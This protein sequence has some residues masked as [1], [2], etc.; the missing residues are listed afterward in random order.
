MLRKLISVVLALVVLAVAVHYLFGFET[1]YVDSLRGLDLRTIL[2]PFMAVAV[3]LALI[4]HFV[5]KRA[6]DAENTDGSVTRK[7]LEAN[8]AF[9][10]TVFLA[11]WVFGDWLGGP[12]TATS[13]ETVVLRVLGI[14]VA[15]PQSGR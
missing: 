12:M 1:R 15:L 14:G 5:G 13:R 4:V 6:L 11:L 10:A 3:V 2:D 8:L 9:Y 7:Y